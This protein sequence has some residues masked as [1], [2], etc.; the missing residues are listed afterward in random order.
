MS[1]VS[2]ERFI[3]FVASSGLVPEDRLKSTIAGLRE[4][5]PSAIADSEKLGDCFVQAQLLTPWQCKNLMQGKYTGYFLGDYRILNYVGDTE[6]GMI[7]QVAHA[8][9]PSLYEMEVIPRSPLG[10]GGHRYRIVREIARES[11]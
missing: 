7:Y 9:K 8:L 3:E 10:G 4:T 5:K 11:E 1:K 6:T 2:P